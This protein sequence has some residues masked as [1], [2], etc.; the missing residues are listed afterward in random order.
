[1]RDVQTLVRLGV[2]DAGEVLTLQRAAY[3]TEAQAHDD[4]DL[5]PLRQALS[6]LAAELADPAV[7]AL[8]WRDANGRLVAAVRGRVVDS[9]RTAA[10]IG[11]LA[12][13]P[14][15]QGERLGARLLAAVEAELPASVT[16]LRLFTGEHSTRNLRFYDRA[17]YTETGRQPI[18]AGYS[19]VHLRKRRSTSR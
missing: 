19:L 4:L 3:V 16:E 18:P 13:A 12:V 6:D 8:G 17:G 9:A 14:D 7:L 5:P 1:M 2:E 15:R 10:E 11:R